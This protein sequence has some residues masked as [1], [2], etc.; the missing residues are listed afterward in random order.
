MSSALPIISLIS[1]DEKSEID[2]TTKDRSPDRSRNGLKRNHSL[3]L[4]IDC[5]KPK[6]G[7]DEIIQIDDQ[8]TEKIEGTKK[9]ITP[10]FKAMSTF[11]LGKRKK[12][13]IAYF[14][15]NKKIYHHINDRKNLRKK[16]TLDEYEYN[17]II[18][19]ADAIKKIVDEYKTGASNVF[20]DYSR[21]FSLG[22]TKTLAVNFFRGKCF[23]HINTREGVFK[24]EKISLNEYEFYALIN[25]NSEIM[26]E[27][28][29]IKKFASKTHDNPDQNDAPENPIKNENSPDQPIKQNVTPENPIKNLNSPDQPIKKTSDNPLQN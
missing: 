13:T 12:I 25:Q 11:S 9:K 23:F 8:E 21:V 1:G 5:K 19:L 6:E 10:S 15:K 4:K 18:S 16:I 22:M 29:E 27:R 7:D 2:K 24:S 28:D 14:D 3:K 17:K 20:D 26:Q